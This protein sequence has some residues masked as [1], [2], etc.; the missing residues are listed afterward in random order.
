MKNLLIDL[1]NKDANHGQIEKAFSKTYFQKWGLNYLLSFLRFQVMEQCGNF[2]D[3]SL[4]L[5]ES[6]DFK[7][8]RKIGNKIFIQLPP[9]ENIVVE[10]KLIILILKIFVIIHM[11]DA[12]MEML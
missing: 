5:Y 1:K 11:V 8:L 3:Q 9:P 6:D 10:R 7:N 4:K 2:K 12:L